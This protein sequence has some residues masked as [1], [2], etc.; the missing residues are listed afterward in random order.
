MLEIN[1]IKKNLSFFRRFF[2]RTLAAAVVNFEPVILI[3]LRG[4]ILGTVQTLSFL[5]GVMGRIFFC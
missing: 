3:F 1:Y 4:Y 2:K 5:G